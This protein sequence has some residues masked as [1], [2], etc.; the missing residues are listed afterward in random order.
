LVAEALDECAVEISILEY[1]A[2][3]NSDRLGK[4]Y[5][6]PRGYFEKAVGKVC[7]KYDLV[8]NELSMETALEN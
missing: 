8:R 2:A 3:A 1:T 5:R 4:K 7:K 6:V